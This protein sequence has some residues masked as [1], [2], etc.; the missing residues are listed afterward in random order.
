MEYTGES[1]PSNRARMRWLRARK[2]SRRWRAS[3]S[4]KA[5]ARKIRTPARLTPAWRACRRCTSRSALKSCSSMTAA[6]SP[7]TPARPVSR[8]GSMTSAARGCSTHSSSQPG[9]H[10]KRTKRSAD[11]AS[12]YG[13]DSFSPMPP[14]GQRN[15]TVASRLR[16]TGTWPR[17]VIISIAQWALRNRGELLNPKTALSPGSCPSSQPRG[18]R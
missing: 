17:P 8:S 9:V 5:A 4:V 2:P 3:S 6:A 18:H 7:S 10:L 15:L 14:G 1:L 11:L 16:R 13:P 12:G